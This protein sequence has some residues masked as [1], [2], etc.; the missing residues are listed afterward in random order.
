MGG[1]LP[2][3]TAKG[4]VPCLAMI[5]ERL[6]AGDGVLLKRFILNWNVGDI[7]QWWAMT[8]RFISPS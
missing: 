4:A 8:A 7:V 2:D 5:V 3:N 6:L 1:V